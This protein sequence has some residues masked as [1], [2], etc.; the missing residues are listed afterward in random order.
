MKGTDAIARVLQAE[1]VE[2]VTCFPM[3]QILDAA[4]ALKIRPVVSR[5]ERVAVNMADG[6]SRMT[7]GRKIGVSVVQYGPGAENAFG[8]M[9]QAFG[10]STPLICLAGSL[11]RARL[12]IPPNFKV[13]RNFKHIAKWAETVTDVQRIPQMLQ[14]A[15]ALAG[16]GNPGPCFSNFQ[17]M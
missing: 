11:E 7:G 5:T 14:H 1:G 17:A 4:A 3:N 10:D 16:S 8:G 12:S 15:F 2:F 6:Y 13:S 9:A